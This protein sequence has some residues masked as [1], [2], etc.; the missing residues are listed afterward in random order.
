MKKVLSTL[1]A[2]LIA[3]NAFAIDPSGSRMDYGDNGM[4]IPTPLLL[5]GLLIATIGCF[6]MGNFK[7]KD[8]KRDAP[9]MIWLGI[10]GVIGVIFILGNI[11]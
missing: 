5:L 3:A 10:L 2:A 11:S 7:N 9:G 6:W 8:G 1:S 4:S